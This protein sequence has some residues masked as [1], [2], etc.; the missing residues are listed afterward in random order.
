MRKV[1]FNLVK[2]GP[3]VGILMAALLV[4]NAPSDLRG[5]TSLPSVNPYTFVASRNVFGLIQESSVETKAS[6][7]SAGAPPQITLVGITTI[8]GRPQVLFN[9]AGIPAPGITVSETSHNFGVGEAESNVKVI[10]ISADGNS[11]TF[12]NNGT[13]PSFTTAKICQVVEA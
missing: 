5:Q 7:L 3:I 12:D 10:E 9:V 6:R 8:L 11:V 2:I 1:D 13:I 4:T